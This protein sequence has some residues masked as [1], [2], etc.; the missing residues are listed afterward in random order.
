MKTAARMNAITTIQTC[1]EIPS[2][3][4]LPS[5]R[6][7]NGRLEKVWPPEIPRV[8][9]RSRISIAR[10]TMKALSASLP[11][12]KPLNNPIAAH[13]TNMMTIARMGL[14]SQPKPPTVAGIT[15]QTASIGPRP[16]TDSRDR[17][18]YPEIRMMLSAITTMP[19]TAE[20]TRTLLTRL[21]TVRNRGVRIAPMMMATTMTGSRTSSRSQLTRSSGFRLVLGAAPGVSAPTLVVVVMRSSPL[22]RRPARRPIADDWCGTGGAGSSSRG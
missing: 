19:S 5:T 11:I 20:T 12:M 3:F 10:V 15:S 1:T 9:P 14:S 22:R 8:I 21:F 4:A 2:S 18:K 17:S 16:T 6:N 13:T 7:R